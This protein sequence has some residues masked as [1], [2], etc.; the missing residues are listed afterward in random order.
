MLLY[1]NKSHT[2]IRKYTKPRQEKPARVWSYDG[3][4]LGSRILDCI[5]AWVVGVVIIA[6]VDICHILIW[7]DMN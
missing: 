3:V 5:E 6:A 4:W 7:I 1:A 2:K